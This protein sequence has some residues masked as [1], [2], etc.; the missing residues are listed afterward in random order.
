MR[1]LVVAGGGPVG[2]AAA[3]YAARAGLDVV[4]REPRPGVLDKACGEGLMPGAVDRLALLGVRPTGH[5]LAGIRYLDARHE[6]EAPFRHG[7]GLGVRRTTLHAALRAAVSAAGVEVTG[8][9]VREVTQHGDH[10]VVDGEPARHLIAA[11]GLHSPVRRLVGLESVP[12]RLRRY[13]QRVHLDLPP[14]T[15][16]V[17]VHWGGCAEAYVT[18]V[19]PDQVGLAILTT[20]RRPFL[21]LLAE[22][23]VLAAR[24]A[25]RPTSRVRGAGPL[26]QRVRRR[27]SGRVLLVGDAAGY[28]DALTGDGLAVGL[29]QAEAA[30][31]A[32]VAGRPADYETV[33]RRLGRRH[34]LLTLGLV[35]ATRAPV[36]RSR[37][38]GA[39]HRLPGLFGAAVDQ[40]ARPV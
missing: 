29:A 17:E 13:G 3:L 5:R 20:Q 18:P 39:A 1:D 40:L 23:P 27:V 4:V 37:I 38:V 25:G 33:A 31:A 15:P 21:D 35:S 10:L 8:P 34:D 16:Y 6:V 2:L 19:A 22:F 24:V 14:W 26:R 11:D 30:V 7:T 12:V 9:A 32:V 28:V 36:V